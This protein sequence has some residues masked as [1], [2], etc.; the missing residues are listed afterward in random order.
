MDRETGE[1]LGGDRFGTS[2][3]LSEYIAV[4]GAPGNAQDQRPDVWRGK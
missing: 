4:V 2:V 3:A 1:G